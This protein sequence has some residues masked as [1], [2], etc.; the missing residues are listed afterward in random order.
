MILSYSLRLVCLCPAFFFLSSPGERER[1]RHQPSPPQKSL[2]LRAVCNPHSAVSERQLAAI[3]S[4]GID[5]QRSGRNS[6]AS[7]ADGRPWAMPFLNEG[8]AV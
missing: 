7:R 2:N 6:R 8:P 3:E 4:A 5:S 1:V